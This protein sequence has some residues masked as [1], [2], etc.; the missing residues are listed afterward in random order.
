MNRIT[1][2]LTSGNKYFVKPTQHTT[3]RAQAPL[4][5]RGF[6]SEAHLDKKDVTERVINVVKSFHKVGKTAEITADT[7]FANDLGLDSL[8]AV[9][10]VMAFEDEFCVDIPDAEADKIQ[11]TADAIKYILTNPQAK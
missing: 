4:F 6:A 2:V 7:H 1:K 3:F 8:D 5:A 9:E 11:S 10:V